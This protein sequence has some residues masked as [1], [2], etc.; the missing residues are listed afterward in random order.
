[1]KKVF[2]LIVLYSTIAATIYCSCYAFA[3]IS[4]LAMAETPEDSKEAAIA[5]GI[6][7]SAAAISFT[8]AVVDVIWIVRSCRRKHALGLPPNV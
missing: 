6:W 1:M 2:H 7:S 3:M 4:G 5:V 8:V